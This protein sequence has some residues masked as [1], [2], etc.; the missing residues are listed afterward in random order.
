[1]SRQFALLFALATALSAAAPANAAGNSCPVPKHWGVYAKASDIPRH[2]LV[3][4]VRLKRIG[5]VFWNDHPSNSGQVKALIDLA[6]KIRHA[7]IVIVLDR[8]NENCETF[9]YF[10]EIVDRFGCTKTRCLVGKGP[11]MPGRAPEPDPD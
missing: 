3:N 4:V 11:P 8:G 7:R 5:K 10:A 9:D 1:M 2:S 6:R